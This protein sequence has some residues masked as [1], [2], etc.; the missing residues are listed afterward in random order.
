MQN[1]SR[2]ISSALIL[3]I[4]SACYA[5]PQR[6]QSSTC[7]PESDTTF[8]RTNGSLERISSKLCIPNKGNF[9]LTYDSHHRET[10]LTTPS[11]LTYSLETIPEEYDPSVVDADSDFIL[12]PFN[13]QPYA[14]NGKLLYISARRSTAGDGSGQCGAGVEKFLNV[15]DI[16]TTPSIISKTLISSCLESIELVDSD[17]AEPSLTAF[18]VQN[19]KIHISFLFYKEPESKSAVLSDDFTKLNIN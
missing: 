16:A 18:S 13:L 14:T 2:K 17:R 8:P 12:L 9:S 11:N 10:I 15:I 4:L 6:S 19:K 5:T 3:L 7:N 1:I